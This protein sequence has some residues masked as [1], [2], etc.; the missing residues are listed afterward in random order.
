MLYLREQAV[1][2]TGYPSLDILW[3]AFTHI[4]GYGG[5]SSDPFRTPITADMLGWWEFDHYTGLAL[6]LFVL[7]TAGAALLWRRKPE[8]L[9]LAAAC[10]GMLILSYG[11][12]YALLYPLPLFH[13]ERVTTRFVSLAF[14]GLLFLGL[15]GLENLTTSRAR[16][17]ARLLCGGVLLVALW[18]AW[19]G[20]QP[21]LLAKLEA[22]QPFSAYFPE[23]ATLH[24]ALVE[25]AHQARYHAVVLG[26][27]VFSL[28]S[29]LFLAVWGA[30]PRLRRMLGC[31][32]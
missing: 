8:S 13:S 16:M 24:P 30:S 17:L 1:F 12:C 26:S 31:G 25:K 20:A 9:P 18:D 23:L 2:I 10:L 22:S 21:W 28:A 4:Q 27:G 14:L 6:L 29:L 3:K 7:G 11:K 5:A 19:A 15:R 32:A